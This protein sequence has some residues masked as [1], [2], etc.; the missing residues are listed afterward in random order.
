MMSFLSISFWAQLQMQ[1]KHC[2][3]N[4]RPDGVFIYKGNFGDCSLELSFLFLL[5]R[6]LCIILQFKIKVFCALK[7]KIFHVM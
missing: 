2:E 1:T 6:L 3:V 7:H 5:M 4:W